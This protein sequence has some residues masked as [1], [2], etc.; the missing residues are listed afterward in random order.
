M[1]APRESRLQA[2]LCGCENDAR[3]LTIRFARGRKLDRS[4]TGHW[5]C[6]VGI[7]T[8]M[9]RHAVP[10]SVE[11][12]T[13]LSSSAAMCGNGSA[14]GGVRRAKQVVLPAKAGTLWPIDSI[15]DVSEILDRPLQC[16]IAHKMDDDKSMCSRSRGALRPR[17]ARSFAHERRGRRECRVHA[18]P[19]VSCARSTWKCAHEHTGSAETLRPSLRKEVNWPEKP[20]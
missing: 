16:A 18:A 20:S 3:G 9:R 13:S 14:Q 8:A 17:C 10:A 7:S 11:K 19:A 6:Q 1:N 2:T 4:E 5:R 15:I 12:L